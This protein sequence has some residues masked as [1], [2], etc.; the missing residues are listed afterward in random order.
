MRLFED[1][2]KSRYHLRPPGPR[3]IEGAAL[4]QALD[5]PLVH[6][7]QIHPAAEVAQRFELP[8]RVSLLK[9]PVDGR[10]SHILHRRQSE[11]DLSFKDRKISVTLV[12]IRGK[13]LDL[14]L[15]ALGN[16]LDD[17]VGI[18]RFTRQQSGHEFDGIMGLQVSG[19]IGEKRIGGAV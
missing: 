12:D 15:P 5:H 9:D 19:L 14:H 2:L 6:F 17:L 11:P 13:D 8:F 16:V 7:P 3:A 4:N 18:L 10:I 1:L